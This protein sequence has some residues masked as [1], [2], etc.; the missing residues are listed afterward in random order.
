MNEF[1]HSILN[2]YLHVLNTPFDVIEYFSTPVAEAD[3]LHQIAKDSE[4]KLIN[5]PA[6]LH[7]QTDPVRYNEDSDNFFN[8]NAYPGRSTI[9]SN[10]AAAKKYPGSRVD[11]RRRIRVVYEN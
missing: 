11:R 1:E 5:L 10:L 8:C 3:F 9:V 7:I 4:K 2:S 6:N